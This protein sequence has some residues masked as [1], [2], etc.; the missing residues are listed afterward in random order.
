MT[1][2]LHNPT[3][4]NS[5]AIEQKANS[6][7]KQT[8]HVLLNSPICLPDQKVPLSG[9]DCCTNLSQCCLSLLG[10]KTIVGTPGGRSSGG[11]MRSV[12]IS[13][14]VGHTGGAAQSP[15]SLSSTTTWESTR[16]SGASQREHDEHKDGAMAPPHR[17]TNGRQMWRKSRPM[18]RGVD[19]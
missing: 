15:G 5:V 14:R 12:G 13:E 3:F 16:G 11:M 1:N 8:H 10:R 7:P 18:V 17:E 2:E 4:T 9:V 6:A 19:T